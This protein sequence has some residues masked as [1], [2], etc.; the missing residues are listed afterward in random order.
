VARPHEA[1]KG[2]VAS[3]G[4][5]ASEDACSVVTFEVCTSSCTAIQRQLPGKARFKA[6][7]IIST[8][9]DIQAT[10]AAQVRLIITSHSAATATACYVILES[11]LLSGLRQPQ[12][13]RNDHC[14]TSVLATQRHLKHFDPLG[15]GSNL[16]TVHVAGRWDGAGSIAHGTQTIWVHLKSRSYELGFLLPLQLLQH[17]RNHLVQCH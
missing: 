8:I 17:L 12:C 13:S 7:V 15:L 11:M 10:Q 5:E 16:G 2:A 6:A 1:G 4:Q 3:K 9:I 14:R